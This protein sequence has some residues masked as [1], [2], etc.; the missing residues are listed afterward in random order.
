MSDID[1]SQI[2]DIHRLLIYSFASKFRWA[3][4][5]SSFRSSREMNFNSALLFIWLLTAKYTIYLKEIINRT[6]LIPG[7]VA[8]RFADNNDLVIQRTK[9]KFGQRAFSVAGLRIWN[10]LP[11]ELKTTIDRLHPTSISNFNYRP[12][13]TSISKGTLY[14]QVGLH[15]TSGPLL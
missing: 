9:L 1:R 12:P 13:F 14:R 8:N 2:I 3:I 7:R 11:T 15:R 5:F 4:C 10:Q 6:K